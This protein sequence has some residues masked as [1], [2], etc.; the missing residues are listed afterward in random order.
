MH[1]NPFVDEVGI[2]VVGQGDVGNRGVRLRT[3]G[4]DLVR[5]LGRQAARS[6]RGGTEGMSRG[7][8]TGR[9]F[10]GSS[11]RAAPYTGYRTRGISLAETCAGMSVFPKGW[12]QGMGSTDRTGQKTAG[13]P[14]DFQRTRGR[15]PA[16]KC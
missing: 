9:R 6:E 2:E 16:G 12:G 10:H 7:G 1:P 5:A 11:L 3:F 4:N 8:P 15:K 13:D 14:G